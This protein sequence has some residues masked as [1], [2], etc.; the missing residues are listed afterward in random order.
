MAAGHYDGLVRTL[1]SVV[2]ADVKRREFIALFGGAAAT[3]SLRRARSRGQR[4]SSVFEID[5]AFAGLAQS[6][7][8]ALVIQ[9]DPVFNGRRDQLVALADGHRIPMIAEWHGFPA[10]GGLI[11]YGTRLT[12]VYH[13]IG[14]YVA[15]ILDGAKPS[16]LP[17]QQPTK[18]DFIINLKTAK[19]LGLT[20]PPSVLVR[21]D[22]VIE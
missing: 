19:A 13:Q 10:E 14:A 6:P 11:S 1:G 5:A 21:A 7:V 18:F 12:E 9:G 20:I 3:L 8:E 2:R 15:K 16:D 17:V 4:T 22:E